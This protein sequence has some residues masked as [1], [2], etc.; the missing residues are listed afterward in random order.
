M[1][2]GV[3]LFTS[4]YLP[5]DTDRSAPDPARPHPVL[6]G[7]LRRRSVQDQPRTHRRI[8]AR[9]LHLRLPGCPGPIHVR[10]RVRQ[11]AAAQPSQ[12]RPASDID[13]STDTYDTIDWLVENLP[14]NN[15][16]VG[17]WGNLLPRVL[18]LRRDDRLA[19]GAQGGLAPG[20]H[21]RLVLR[22][23]APPRRLHPVHGLRVL[24][25]LRQGTR[26]AGDRVARALRLRHPDGYQFFLDLGPLKQ[27]QRAPP[28]R[29]DRVLERDRRPSG[30]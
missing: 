2:D 11:H 5:N 12:E 8:R 7:P 16:R 14:N 27:R 10:G 6:G 24:L 25:H 22:R 30:L 29:R 28:P 4:V 19:P 1:R 3:T 26:G 13:E 9:R 21:R 20:A 15:G 17:M 23:H 18:H